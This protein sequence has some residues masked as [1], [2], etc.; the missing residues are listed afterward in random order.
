MRIGVLAS[1]EGSVLQAI[2]DACGT[3]HEALS[4]RVVYR[5]QQQQRVGC[6]PSRTRRRHSHGA[7]I[8]RD[9]PRT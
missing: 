2:L 9:P 1:H 6:N 7:R 3:S 4:A 5:R 8:V